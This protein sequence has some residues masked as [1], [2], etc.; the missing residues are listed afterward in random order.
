MS[1]A[2][3]NLFLWDGC[4][5][6]TS[7]P[8]QLSYLAETAEEARQGVRALFEQIKS[9]ELE[10]VKVT[11]EKK[12]VNQ[13]RMALGEEIHMDNKREVDTEAKEKVLREMT[14]QMCQMD[15][16]L[17]DKVDANLFLGPYTED[18]FVINLQTK[19]YNPY[20]DEGK[21][22]TLNELLE[23]APKQSKLKRGFFSIAL[24]G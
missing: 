7:N 8:F 12:E 24:Q 21:A 10:R 2:Q 9:L 19:V 15:M 6:R 1:F 23:T 3:M 14:D 5:D 16:E 20:L 11:E 17:R 4:V 22:M 13:Q 18:I